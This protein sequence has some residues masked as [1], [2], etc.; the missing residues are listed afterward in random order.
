MAQRQWRMMATTD[1]DTMEAFFAVEVPHLSYFI[2]VASY[3]VRWKRPTPQASLSSHSYGFALTI[4][5]GDRRAHVVAL[6]S[7]VVL[8][9]TPASASKHVLPFLWVSRKLPS[10]GEW[11]LLRGARICWWCRQSFGCGFSSGLSV[12]GV[13]VVERG[14]R[15]CSG[16]GLPGFS[17][18]DAPS[19]W[20]SFQRHVRIERERG[21]VLP[22]WFATARPVPPNASF[23]NGSVLPTQVFSL[24]TRVH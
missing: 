8:L 13:L 17:Q 7:A 10:S 6:G 5:D 22:A 20:F 14:F 3:I 18:A 11:E 1:D 12:M 23:Y 15:C 9:E 19:A 16:L 21:R 4:S 24:P 2:S